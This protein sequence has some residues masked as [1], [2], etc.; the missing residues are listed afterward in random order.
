MQTATAWRAEA[1]TKAALVAGRADVLAGV[2]VLLVDRDGGVVATTGP[3]V[4]VA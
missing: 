1:A 3:E 4:L 2:H